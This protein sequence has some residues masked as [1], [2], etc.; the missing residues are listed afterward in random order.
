[1]TLPDYMT[2]FGMTD[3]RAAEIFGYDRTTI[4]RLR[5]GILT[6]SYDKMMEI[7]DKTHGAVTVESW[8]ALKSDRRKREGAEA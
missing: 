4:S 3:D 8:S 6:P 5:R 1:M 7:Q 2:Q